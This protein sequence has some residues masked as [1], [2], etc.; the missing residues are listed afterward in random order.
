MVCM[1]MEKRLLICQEL[2][3]C[4]SSTVIREVFYSCI[5]L[6][7]V[8]FY[9]ICMVLTSNLLYLTSFLQSWFS[10]YKRY[11]YSIYIFKYLFLL[12]PKSHRIPSKSLWLTLQKYV[13]R[14]QAQC[15][16]PYNHNVLCVLS[17]TQGNMIQRKFL[18]VDWQKYLYRLL[19]LFRKKKSIQTA[20]FI[21][22]KKEIEDCYTEIARHI[23][24]SPYFCVY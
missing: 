17:V 23:L 19:I 12:L 10:F 5:I 1:E 14:S 2:V 9:T 4:V 18:L 3:P 24:T 16:K 15:H 21:H 7:V 6:L 22:L 20:Y 13:V 11:I 8:S